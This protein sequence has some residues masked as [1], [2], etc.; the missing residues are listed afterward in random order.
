MYF[1]WPKVHIGKCLL[2][3]VTYKTNKHNIPT[4]GPKYKRD[5]TCWGPKETIENAYLGALISILI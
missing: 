2:W 5:N 4:L 3:G 1:R